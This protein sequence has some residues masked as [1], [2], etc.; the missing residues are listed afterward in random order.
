MRQN[1]FK[2]LKT[3]K[4][5]LGIGFGIFISPA[6][7]CSPV[8][9]IPFREAAVPD[10]YEAHRIHAHTRISPLAHSK[11]EASAQ[12]QIRS[13]KKAHT[14]P[15]QAWLSAYKNAGAGFKNL[16]APAFTR[17]IKTQAEDPI[18]PS[19]VPVD[20]QGQPQLKQIENQVQPMV[21][22]AH[23]A[24]RKFLAY[25]WDVSDTR[26]FKLHP[27]WGCKSVNGTPT[28]HQAKGQYLDIS[29]PFGEI[30]S[31]RLQELQSYDV[32]GV[33][34]DF[35]H[36][37]PEGCYGTALESSFHQANPNFARRDKTSLAYQEALKQ[38]QAKTMATVMNRWSDQFR[39]DPNFA[40]IVSTTS[41]P[42]LVN[43]EMTTDLA[44]AGI[45]KTEYH[46]ATRPGINLGLFRTNPDLMLNKPS[47]AVQMALGWNLLRS[48]S[49]AP[50][51]VWINGVPTYEQLFSAVGAVVTHGG[52]A[53]IDVD[54]LNIT[55]A[56]NRQGATPR[57][58]LEKIFALDKQLGPLFDKTVPVRR[59]AVHFSEEARNKRN[60]RK[61][62]TEVAGP[63]TEV[64]ELLLDKQV[65]TA[66]IDD[67]IL[68][69]GDLSAY[70]Y[71]IS[72]T[73][74]ELS[75]QQQENIDRNNV[76]LLPIKAPSLFNRS[77]NYRKALAPLLNN[78]STRPVTIE[79]LPEGYHA[80]LWSAPHK[81]RTLLSIVAP[82][83]AQV[84]TQTLANPLS[85]QA[86]KSMPSQR[87]QPVS[88]EIDWKQLGYSNQAICAIDGLT[89][90]SLGRAHQQVQFELKAQWHLLSFEPCS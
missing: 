85:K 80:V 49:G 5:S 18:W 29:S 10:W 57:D 24:G 74:S 39:N 42:T 78:P 82:S 83:F 41:L 3:A 19:A 77:Q 4:L 38:F 72:P 7:S 23:A 34:L 79:A 13:G 73:A 59:V 50:P 48:V 86:V 51:H 1:P 53:N 28:G 25:Y 16:G 61:R 14:S 54:E 33:Y 70:Q 47:D 45:P 27:E 90:Q 12:Q 64:F 21:K 43:P 52:V 32:D 17:H 44:R 37:P 76:K 15:V 88:V 22:E 65:P 75:T 8:E 55:A 11:Y 46:V 62:W 60:L 63:V 6:I 9:S 81:Q 67:R 20:A 2:S 66:V 30:V 68:A 31:Q 71:I 58:V 56:V 69:E 35:R 40:F 26:M 84:Q 87:N 36:Y 89:G